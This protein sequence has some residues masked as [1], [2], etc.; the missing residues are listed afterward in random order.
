MTWPTTGLL[1]DFNRAD[2]TGLGANW[3]ADTM[4]ESLVAP[5]VSGNQA[6]RGASVSAAF[7]NVA[8]YGP[9]SEA[10][11][12]V[13]A[14]TANQAI[15]LTLRVLSA[16]GVGTADGYYMEVQRND[17]PDGWYIFRYDNSVG[18]QLG[19]AASIAFITLALGWIVFSSRADEFT[20]RV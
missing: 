9:D 11:Y 18:T 2:S 20:Y 6:A 12:D 1:D 5:N 4:G 17:T 10:F 16:G 3:T 19:A 8:T 14:L 7:Y 13:A 15:G